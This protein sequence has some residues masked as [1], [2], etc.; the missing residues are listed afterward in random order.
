VIK[1]VTYSSLKLVSSMTITVNIEAIQA[2]LSNLD[3][4][5]V[6]D[7]LAFYNELEQQATKF[8]V[9]QPLPPLPLD[10]SRWITSLPPKPIRLGQPYHSTVHVAPKPDAKTLE[11]RRY[12]I[13]N[14]NWEALRETLHIDAPITS[15]LVHYE[16]LRFICFSS[17]TVFSLDRRQ[18]QVFKDFWCVWDFD[19]DHVCVVASDSLDDNVKTG[20]DGSTSLPMDLVM[21]GSLTTINSTVATRPVAQLPKQTSSFIF[22]RKFAKLLKKHPMV[23]VAIDDRRKDFHT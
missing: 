15:P 22:G 14:T 8:K 6:V 1:M 17:I 11:R 18:N 9:A 13:E 7:P 2:C 5:N 19:A 23:P 16:N 20:V 10:P 3:L 21:W 12:I 4:L